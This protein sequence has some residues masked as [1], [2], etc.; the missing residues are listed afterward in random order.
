MESVTNTW[1]KIVKKIT[2]V[3]KKG[4]QIGILWWNYLQMYNILEIIDIY[5]WN[6]LE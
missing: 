4:S 5:F 6:I 2:Y 1:N 3:L